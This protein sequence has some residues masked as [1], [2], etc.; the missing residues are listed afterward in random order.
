MLN[1]TA[2]KR[3]HATQREAVMSGRELFVEN[4]WVKIHNNKHTH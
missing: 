3:A 1:K 4:H 2:G